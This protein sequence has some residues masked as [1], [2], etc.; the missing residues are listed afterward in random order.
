MTNIYKNVFSV[1]L[2]LFKQ[3]QHRINPK[4]EKH[5]LSRRKKNNCKLQMRY[6]ANL[7]DILHIFNIHSNFLCSPGTACYLKCCHQYA[8]VVVDA[9][10]LQSSTSVA[11]FIIQYFPR[12][13][14]TNWNQTWQTC[15]F[16]MF[17]DIAWDSDTQHDRQKQLCYKY[18]WLKFQIFSSWKSCT[19]LV[20]FCLISSLRQASYL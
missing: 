9:V 1:F 8:F 18:D 2:H 5:V 13:H 19:C 4:D 11:L 12:N 15:N 10:H 16:D 6:S 14:Q 3:R 17:I 7:Y 20:I